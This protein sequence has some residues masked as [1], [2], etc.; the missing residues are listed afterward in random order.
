LCESQSIEEKKPQN[1]LKHCGSRAVVFN[2]G[3]AEH[4]GAVESSRGASFPSWFIQRYSR[5]KGN[6]K[7][8]SEHV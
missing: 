5:K 8:N 2:R 1:E 4:L 7:K 3:V 6:S